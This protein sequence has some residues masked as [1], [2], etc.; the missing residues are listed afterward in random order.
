MWEL[1]VSS[2]KCV[3]LSSLV[4]LLPCLMETNGGKKGETL[5][6]FHRG[7]YHRNVCMYEPSKQP[8]TERF[9]FLASAGGNPDRRVVPAFSKCDP[10][11][12]LASSFVAAGSLDGTHRQTISVFFPIS[13]FAQWL[14]RASCSL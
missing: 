6:T 8:T 3:R 4:A 5:L 7:R 14:M 2:H 13:V 10:R 11:G 9:R 1:V 12:F